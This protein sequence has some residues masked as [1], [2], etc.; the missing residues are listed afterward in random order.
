MK[1]VKPMNCEQFTNHLLTL[2]DGDEIN[3]ACFLGVDQEEMERY[4][5]NDAECWYFAKVMV[6]PE[7]D[8]RFILIDYCGGEEA[9]AIPLNNYADR[10]DEDDMH[11]VPTYVKEFFQRCISLGSVQ[12]TV[13]V[14][15]EEDD[16]E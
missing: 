7:Y 13:Y 8:S 15:F 5:V 14:V 10:R 6:I 16:D 9:Y 12:H 2:K 3:F 4:D 11:I 1:Y